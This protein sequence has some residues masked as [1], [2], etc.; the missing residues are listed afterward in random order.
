MFFH[1]AC[2]GSPIPLWHIEHLNDP[3]AVR[4]VTADALILDDGRRVPLPHVTKLPVDSPVFEAALKRGVEVAPDGSVYGLIR[5]FRGCGHDPVRY[6][7]SRVNL[8]EL[9]AALNPDGIEHAEKYPRDIQRLKA[10]R[11]FQLYSRRGWL[12]NNLR[13]LRDVRRLL[14]RIEREQATNDEKFGS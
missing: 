10:R 8:S 5:I 4:Q 11:S 12:D 6:D 7:V 3:V 1:F 9:A 2:T 13:A 14:D